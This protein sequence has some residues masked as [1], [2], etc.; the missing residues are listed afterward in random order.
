MSDMIYHLNIRTKYFP[1]TDD[2]GYGK[3]KD[4]KFERDERLLRGEL[5]REPDN[6]RTVFYLANTLKARADM[7]KRSPIYKRKA[8]PHHLTRHHNPQQCLR[9]LMFFF[10]TMKL[11]DQ[12]GRNAGAFTRRRQGPRAPP[13]T[14]AERPHRRRLHVATLLDDGPTAK[15]LLRHGN[16][17]VNNR[18]SQGFFSLL[19]AVLHDLL[20]MIRLL[21][22]H[23]K[24]L[25]PDN[26]GMTPWIAACLRGHGE[27]VEVFLAQ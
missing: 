22:A 24:E 6:V 26:T 1:R 16:V 7:R 11:F 3:A 4:D 8:P 19:H 14:A 12:T 15:K 9:R 5:E 10:T 20:G 27:V 25:V 13:R 23:G 21:L 2:V 17:D 18:D